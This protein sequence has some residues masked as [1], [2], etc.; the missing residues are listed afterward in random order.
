MSQ[1]TNF[2]P[3]VNVFKAMTAYSRL[4]ELGAAVNGKAMPD[5]TFNTGEATYN[6]YVTTEQ[7]VQGYRINLND[8]SFDQPGSKWTISAEDVMESM[9]HLYEG[10]HKGKLPFVMMVKD[11]TDEVKLFLDGSIVIK[12]E[13]GGHLAE[14]AERHPDMVT[15]SLENILTS[16][17]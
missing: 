15:K 13:R 8:K 3:I 5:L 1:V 10:N 14:M 6:L 11:A 2:H 4:L 9:I 7:D 16:V 17:V 12:S